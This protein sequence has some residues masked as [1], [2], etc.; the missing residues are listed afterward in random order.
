[1]DEK[2]Y[3]YLFACALI[4]AVAVVHGRTRSLVER[5]EKK[6][7]TDMDEICTPDRAS[8]VAAE[9]VDTPQSQVDLSSFLN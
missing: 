5:F 1:M 6:E 3:L 2:C 8:V 9:P 7:K 4:L